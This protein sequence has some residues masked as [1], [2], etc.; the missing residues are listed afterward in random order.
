MLSII[1]RS[2]KEELED[3]YLN[4]MKENDVKPNNITFLVLIKSATIKRDFERAKKY[5]QIMKTEGIK[6]E[7]FTLI[8]LVKY[9]VRDE[10]IDLAYHFLEEMSSS[11]FQIPIDCFNYIAIFYCNSYQLENTKKL[12]KT[13]EKYKYITP[14]NLIHIENLI[15]KFKVQSGELDE[16]YEYL[17]K[18][19]EKYKTADVH[20]F[21]TVLSGFAQKGYADKAQ[22]IF[23]LMLQYKVAPNVVSYSSLI[24][25]YCKSHQLIQAESLRKT[26]IDNGI[27]PNDVTFG[28]LASSWF[29]K[30]QYGKVM[31]EFQFFCENQILLT[32]SLA[33][34]LVINLLN[35]NK[36]FYTT[37]IIAYMLDNQITINNIQKIRFILA[38]ID[39][40][41]LTQKLPFLQR[42]LADTHLTYDDFV[43][44]IDNV[45][46]PNCDVKNILATHL[47]IV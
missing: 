24:L 10:K 29:F 16:S 1:T 22:E 28:T 34:Y 12:I 42:L 30:K 5:L 44:Y 7:I 37:Q 20:T 23:D 43:P 47:Q 11:G 3:F 2:E 17:M 14:M 32:R 41:Q 26:M 36:L 35:G 4:E 33:N 19:L 25:A 27:F 18:L 39:H 15:L 46:K 8:D 13:M 40:N 21:T 6:P 45:T 9:A 38:L 31:N